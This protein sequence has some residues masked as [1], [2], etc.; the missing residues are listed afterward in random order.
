MGQWQIELL[1]PAHDRIAFDCGQ[2]S[3]NQ[4]LK[5]RA[6]QWQ[7][8]ELVRCHVAVPTA[9]SR[10][11]GFYAICSHHVSYEL[12]P[13]DQAKG[14]PKID[15]PVVLPARLAVDRTVQGHG[16]GRLLLVDALRRAEWLAR[17]VGIR[18]VEVDA[19][20]DDA[21]RFY[22]KFGFTPLADD[23]NHLFL[24]MHLVRKL[25]LGSE[26]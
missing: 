10:V 14:L 18:A 1:Q 22:L 5:Q 12:L 3:L 24:P 19:I 4:W 17:Q 25:Q 6:G 20:D 16:L 26:L 11:V 15:V 23:A 13:A 7:R 21:R 8:R 2:E 9:Q